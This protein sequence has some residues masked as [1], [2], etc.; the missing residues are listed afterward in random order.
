MAIGLGPRDNGLYR[1]KSETV[2][3]N[4]EKYDQSASQSELPSQAHNQQRVP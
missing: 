1:H 3:E 2:H 4:V